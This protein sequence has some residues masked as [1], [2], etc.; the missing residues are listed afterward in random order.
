MNSTPQ[1]NS[2]SQSTEHS[3]GKQRTYSGNSVVA[4]AEFSRLKS[5]DM[6][7]SYNDL[8]FSCDSQSAYIEPPDSSNKSRS[9][10]S[11]V[12]SVSLLE[13]ILRGRQRGR[14]GHR[15]EIRFCRDVFKTPKVVRP[16]IPLSNPVQPLCSPTTC[17]GPV[18]GNCA[19]RE[20]FR[21]RSSSDI[22]LDNYAK[23]G[24]A[25]L[26]LVQ[27]PKVYGRARCLSGAGK[28]RGS[29]NYPTSVEV[30]KCAKAEP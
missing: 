11:L 13:H 2:S 23:R 10:F 5:L 18:A 16:T 9:T 20:Y 12:Q 25:L 4:R 30:I 29:F 27:K 8:C 3:V 22:L 26:K 24:V 14:D 6:A 17:P 7:E 28:E 19:A 15:E 1:S 21:N